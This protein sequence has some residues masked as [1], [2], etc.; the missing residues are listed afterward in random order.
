MRLINIYLHFD[1]FILKVT[2]PKVMSEQEKS[3]KED[4]V[5]VPDNLSRVSD[6]VTD[7]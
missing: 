4:T 3:V 1:D 6:R 5:K 7:K 2:V